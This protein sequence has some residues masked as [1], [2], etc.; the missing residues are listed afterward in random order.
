MELSKSLLDCAHI[1]LDCLM[2]RMGRMGR[3]V[4]MVALQR[5][6]PHIAYLINY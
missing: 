6:A 5:A 4:R 1:L 3:M 2:G